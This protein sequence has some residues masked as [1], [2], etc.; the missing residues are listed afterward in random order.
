V[1]TPLRAG[2]IGASGIGKHHVKWLKNLGCEV[3]GFAGTTEERVAATA[4]SL[5]DQ[6]GFEGQGY[7]GVEALLGQGLDVLSVCSPPAQHF[8]HVMMAARRGV[9][10]LCEKPLV[11]DSARAHRLLLAD[12]EELVDAVADA[13]LVGATNTQYVAAVEPIRELLSGAGL[14]ASTPRYVFMQMESRGGPQGSEFEKIWVDLASHPI[15]VI[16]ALAGPG[17]IIAGSTEATVEQRRCEARFRWRGAG[18]RETEGHVLVRNVPEGPLTR[19]IIVDDAVLEYEGRN[20]E[21]GVYATY[22]K[23]GG[24]EVRAEDFVCTSIRRFLAAVR[25]RGRPLA[26]LA[27]GLENLRLQLH[28]LDVARAA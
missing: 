22:L 27:D 24:A 20:D 12:A 21:N 25:G 23:L 11:Y 18:G 28:L 26:S 14:E 8:R 16:L 2:V 9:H 5:R 17:E 19:R 13:D 1:A 6:F 15:S 4:Q 10:V 3:V 7:V